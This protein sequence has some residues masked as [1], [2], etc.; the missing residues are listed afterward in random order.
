MNSTAE[1]IPA[2]DKNSTLPWVCLVAASFSILLS[3]FMVQ[4]DAFI[5]DDG[6]LYLEIARLFEQGNW[7][8]SFNL[9][10]WAFISVLIA[11]LHQVSGLSLTT[12]GY[13]IMA[14]L[15][16]MVVVSF[17]LVISRI[18]TKPSVLIAAA[19]TILV[20]PKL[21]VYPWHGQSLHGKSIEYLECYC[22]KN[23]QKTAGK[24]DITSPSSRY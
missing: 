16:A 22:G 21:N 2:E 18:S 19:I 15:N 14:G 1:I 4:N 3:V 6:L 24:T 12:G 9:Q 7:T 13:T 23:I 11:V 17:I 10:N 8:Q 20:Y 5:N